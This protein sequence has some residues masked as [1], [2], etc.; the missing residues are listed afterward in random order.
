V[1]VKRTKKETALTRHR[2]WLADLQRTN[3]QLKKASSDEA[4]AKVLLA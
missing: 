1:A 2:K 3:D 4:A